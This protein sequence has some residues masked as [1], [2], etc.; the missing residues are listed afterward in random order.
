[1]KPTDANPEDWNL[2]YHRT[3]ML[4]RNRGPVLV[5]VGGKK[6]IGYL[7]KDRDRGLLHEDSVTLNPKHLEP[8]WPRS[9]AYNWLTASGRNAACYMSRRAQRNMRKSATANSHYI[10]T[11]GSY[12][13]DIMVLAALTQDYPSARKALS[14]I[15]ASEPTKNLD[16]AVSPDLI[17]NKQVGLAGGPPIINVIFK[18]NYAGQLDGMSFD[19]IAPGH[20]LSK[21][22]AIKLAQIGL[23]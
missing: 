3:W 5:I 6:L 20:P 22:A 13:G 10:L 1:M 15:K 16:V 4:D 23:L 11:Y 14:M 9:A 21:R 7:P 12:P 2:Y 18:G 19:P 17:L 8:W